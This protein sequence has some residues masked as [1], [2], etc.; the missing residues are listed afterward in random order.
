VVEPKNIE[1]DNISTPSNLK[2][3]TLLSPS[4]LGSS[5]MKEVCNPMAE[6]HGY[7]I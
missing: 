1:S 7:E 6:K 4:I 3:S 2:L 5:V